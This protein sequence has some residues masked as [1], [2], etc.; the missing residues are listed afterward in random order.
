MG[1]SGVKNHF[2]VLSAMIEQLIRECDSFVRG[3]SFELS[4]W[5]LAFLIRSKGI[6]I[7][8]FEY[9]VL[10][11]RNICDDDVAA[12]YFSGEVDWN[13]CAAELELRMVTRCAGVD[14]IINDYW[15]NNCFEL[16]KNIF[17]EQKEAF[18]IDYSLVD[19]NMEN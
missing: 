8:L 5:D 6:T 15:R 11:L 9:A 18:C 17:A 13:A 3:D 14:G 16:I 10:R 1:D 12:P 19:F 2:E 4:Y 7:S